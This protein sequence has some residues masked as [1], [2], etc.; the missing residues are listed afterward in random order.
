[1]PKCCSSPSGGG[2]MVCRRGQSI[3]SFRRRMEEMEFDPVW[4]VFLLLMVG[5]GGSA[6][7]ILLLQKISELDGDGG[8]EIQGCL[9]MIPGR[10]ATEDRVSSCT[11]GGSFGSQS[12]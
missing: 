1:M 3:D 12:S 7:W 8:F 10:R 9:G 11:V 4:L 6:R 5:D 2:A